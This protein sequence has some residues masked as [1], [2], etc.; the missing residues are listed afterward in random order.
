MDEQNKTPDQGKDQRAE[1]KKFKISRRKF[2]IG[3]GIVGVAASTVG[4]SFYGRKR[5]ITN[6][7]S[8]YNDADFVLIGSGHNTLSCAMLLTRAGHKVLILE[9]S[10]QIG[11]AAKTQEMTLPGFKHDLYATN[12]GLFLGSP[13]FREFKDDLFGQ[14][15]K[16]VVSDF[17]MSSVFPDNTGMAVYKDADK[18]YDNIKQHSKQDADAWVELFAYFNQCA[19]HFLPLLQ[20]PMPSFA[21][22]H[23]SFRL[24]RKL[25]VKGALELAQFLLKSPRQYCAYWFEHPKS[26][27]LF[28]PWAMHLDFGPDVSGGATFPFVEPPIYQTFGMPLSEG[29]VSNLIS[30]MAGVVKKNGGIIQSRRKVEQILVKNGQAIGVQ[31]SD[32]QKIYTR[33]SVIANVTPHQLVG[34]LIAETELPAEYVKKSRK[35]RFGPGTMMIHLALN[36]PVEWAAGREYGSFNYVHIGPYVEDLAKTYTDATNGILPASPMLIVGQLSVT[37]P[38]RAPKGKH[39][40]WIQ[41]RV[42][43]ADPRADALSGEGAIT[44]GPWAKIK[45]RYADRVIKKL[46]QYAPGVSAKI[47]KRVVL[48]PADLEHDDPNL[49]GGDSLA[50]SHHLDQFY[51]FRPI[52]G[53]ARYQTPIRGLYMVGASTWPG[54]G[55][56]ATSGYLLAKDLL[57]RY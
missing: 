10:S 4:Y 16:P 3:T 42:L 8:T 36:G 13:T 31:T 20:R 15:F 32:G 45:E 39:V 51:M 41:V 21:A 2:L 19:P 18:T 25:G 7:D 38:T 22:L 9:G 46:E 28:M 30:S 49:V 26:R 24:T 53:W 1:K 5:G 44:P 56:H 35:Y 23:Q 52:P 37:D 34:Q 14:G 11:G 50:G 33:K 6:P 47:L 40:L 48:S 55:L 17:P 54:A 57:E 43:P 29:G 27:A 12:I